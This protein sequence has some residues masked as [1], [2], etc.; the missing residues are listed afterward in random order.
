MKTKVQHLACPARIQDRIYQNVKSGAIVLS[1][2]RSTQN[3]PGLATVVW[4]HAGNDERVTP[5]KF[6][7]GTAHPSDWADWKP[8]DGPFSIEFYPLD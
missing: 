6:S 3:P 4:L 5:G 2:P 1:T 8:F 7:V